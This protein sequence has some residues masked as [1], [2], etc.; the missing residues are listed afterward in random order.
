M[1]VILYG[2]VITHMYFGLN[3]VLRSSGFPKLAMYATLASV[4]INTILNPIFIFGLGWESK[5]RLSQQ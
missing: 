5:A 3:G 4:V 2:N 1:R